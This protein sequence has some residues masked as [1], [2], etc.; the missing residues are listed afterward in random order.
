MKRGGVVTVKRLII[1]A[2]L[3]LALAP[4][5]WAD[6]AAGKAAY[7]RGDYAAAHKEWQSPAETGNVDA[8]YHLGLL[9]QTG[10]GVPK[11]D[12]QALHWYRKAADKG[13]A[14][15]ANNLGVMYHGG[16]GV[17]Q[18]FAEAGRWY[19]RAADRGN[20]TAQYNLGLLYLGGRGVARSSFDAAE[21]FRKAAASEMPDAMVN[22]GNLYLEGVGVAQ[23]YVRA[24]MWYNLAAARGME[25]GRE[26]RD[27]IAQNM[28]SS[29]IAE[30]QRL[31]REWAS[32]AL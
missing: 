4:P 7:D 12:V 20:A 16:Y 9:Y 19:R 14:D 23:D 26:N 32:G 22:L 21:W 29:E 13:H 18:D 27:L 31:S 11:D 17:V 8:Q 30:A 24:Y 3:V 10:R 15:A 2:V 1:A 5:A 25:L 28:T 6:F